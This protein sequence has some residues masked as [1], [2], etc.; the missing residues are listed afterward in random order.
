MDIKIILK[1]LAEGCSVSGFENYLSETVKEM[2][3]PFCDSVEVNRFNSIICHK[4]CKNGSGR[5]I[6]IEAHLDQIGLI[7]TGIDKMGFVKFMS[8]GGIDKRILPASEVYIWG[9]EKVYGIIGS[10]P[11]HITESSDRDKMPDISGMLIDTG[12]TK[13]ELEKKISIGDSVVLKS[14]LT[15][16][17]NERV[18]CLA[19]DNRAGVASVISAAE[20]LCDAEDDIYYVFTSEEELGLH[21]VY[22]VAR[23][24][25]PDYTIV[26]DVTH[27]MTVDSKDEAGVFELGSG[28]V[29]CKGPA[30]NSDFAAYLISVAEKNRIKHDIEV[31]SGHSGTNAWA[32]QKAYGKCKTALISIPLKYMHTAVEMVSVADVEAVSELLEKALKEGIGNA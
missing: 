12:Y 16:L 1:K 22:S 27:G 23:E 25:Q 15:E 24:I 21:G 5:K 17:A 14:E 31:V 11:P 26:V 2:M 13:D 28:A 8:V 20:R 32:V 6:M 10:K 4:A 3:R 18:S 7:V 29:I 19:L 9:K 30:L